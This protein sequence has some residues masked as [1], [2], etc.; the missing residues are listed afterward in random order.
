MKTNRK[1]LFGN[2]AT[3]VECSHL[4]LVIKTEN[5]YKY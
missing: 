2:V 5:K 4:I 1:T 3:L